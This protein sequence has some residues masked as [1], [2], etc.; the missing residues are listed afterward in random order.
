MEITQPGRKLE[1][2]PDRARRYA[3]DQ[4]VHSGNA[5]F[6]QSSHGEGIRLGVRANRFPPPA[7]AGVAKARTQQKL[8]AATRASLCHGRDGFHDDN[9]VVWQK[10][11]PSR[12]SVP[13]RGQVSAMVG[14]DSTTTIASS[15]AG[16]GGRQN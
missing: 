7:A 13:Q 3:L 12:N 11:E 16:D 5:L 9:R 15:T 8:G 2:A 4:R 14:M 6:P 1:G 10:R